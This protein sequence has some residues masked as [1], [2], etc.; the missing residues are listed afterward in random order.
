MVS[1]YPHEHIGAPVVERLKHEQ[2]E[3]NSMNCKEPKVVFVFTTV[4][5]VNFAS[6][7]F[8]VNLVLTFEKSSSPSFNLHVP[9]PSRNSSVEVH[10]VLSTEVVRY[11]PLIS[12]AK[13]VEKFNA[14]LMAEVIVLLYSV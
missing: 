12:P 4:K 2:L 14:L 13:A 10:F 11:V 7:R 6:E 1:F 8:E 3:L 5:L 9:V